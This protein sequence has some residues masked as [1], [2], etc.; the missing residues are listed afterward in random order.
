[1]AEATHL[2]GL[3]RKHTMKEIKGLLDEFNKYLLLTGG[4]MQG[5][6][7][8]GGYSLYN[9]MMFDISLLVM[10][11][12][13]SGIDMQM[14]PIGN[15]AGLSDVA[16]DIY[17]D[18][19]GTRAL[20]DAPY[21]TWLS[22]ALGKEETL[23]PASSSYR[24]EI[25]VVR[26]STLVPDKA[27][28]CMKGSNPIIYNWE[29]FAPSSAVGVDV[30]SGI[31]NCADATWTAVNFST[32]FSSTPVSVALTILDA[33]SQIQRLTHRNVTVNGFEIWQE[34]KTAATVTVHWIATDAGNP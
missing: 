6:I 7:N 27:Y 15:L 33:G 10:D 21:K 24:G 28:I 22:L 9:S 34:L 13:G 29:Q 16:G 3:P 11:P 8:M 26:G 30:K 4:T 32:P 14:T 20:G 18:S 2:L 17:P 25:R 19:L 31:K 5:S 12:L 1:M 23:P